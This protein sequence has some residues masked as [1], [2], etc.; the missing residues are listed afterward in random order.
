MGGV[1]KGLQAFAGRPLATHALQRL[2]SQ[3]GV[4]LHGVC[5]SANRHIESYAALGSAVFGADRVQVV[6]DLDASF[7]GPLAGFAAAWQACPTDWML[8]VPCDSPRFPLDM[9]QRLYAAAQA[10][11]ADMATVLAPQDDAGGTPQLRLQPVFCLMHRRV[12]AG[13]HT[14]LAGGGRKVGAWSGSLQR[15]QVPFDAPGDDPR[16]FANANTL[17]ELRQLES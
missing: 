13:L 10:A 2:V 15:V 7:A 3:Q 4:R 16:A 12:A 14:Y 8:A 6:P 5:I 11:G 1:D 9:A 17:D